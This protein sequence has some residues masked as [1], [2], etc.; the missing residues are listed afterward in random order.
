MENSTPQRLTSTEP[1]E[2]AP[3]LKYLFFSDDGLI[4]MNQPL[5]KNAFHMLGRNFLSGQK[6]FGFKKGCA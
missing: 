5:L 3:T 4:E 1:P 2:T 6:L